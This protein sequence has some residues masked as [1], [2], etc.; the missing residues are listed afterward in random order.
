MRKLAFILVLAAG[1]HRDSGGADLGSSQGPPLDALAPSSTDAGS[2]GKDASAS[3]GSDDLA[4]SQSTHDLYSAADLSK[5]ADLASAPDLARAPDLA[6]APDLALPPNPNAPFPTPYCTGTPV[7]TAAQLATLYQEAPFAKYTITGMSRDCTTTGCSAWSYWQPE[8]EGA[9]GNG[10]PFVQRPVLTAAGSTSELEL[11]NQY[12]TASN[13]YAGQWYGAT[14]ALDSTG[15][16]S[17][18]TYEW[19]MGQQMLGSGGTYCTAG[20][21]Y[22]HE[23]G[24]GYTMSGILTTGCFEVQTPIEGPSVGTQYAMDIYGTL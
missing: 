9:L 12:C 11:V 22:M 10:S 19:D 6:S 14:C 7:T 24:S 23:T 4:T 2:P 15:H 18:G 3:S 13:A 21:L 1:C 20:E 8:F 16:L 17:C 5:V